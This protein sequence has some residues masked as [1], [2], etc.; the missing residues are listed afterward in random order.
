VVA[1]TQEEIAGMTNTSRETVSR[2]LH[3]F[4]REKLIAVKGA[5]LTVLQPLALE[6]LAS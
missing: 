5:S 6:E 3:Q 2:I 1:L 4:Q